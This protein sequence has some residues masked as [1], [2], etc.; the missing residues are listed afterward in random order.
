MEI[1]KIEITEDEYRILIFAKHENISLH[2]ENENL[3]N[4]IEKI[5]KV[6]I[7]ANSILEFKNI[8]SNPWIN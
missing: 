6:I 2:R 1:T 3:R 7:E 4:K 5:E 8:E